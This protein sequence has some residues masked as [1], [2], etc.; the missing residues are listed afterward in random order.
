M[1]LLFS[2]A[3]RLEFFTKTVESLVKHCPD[4]N[5]LTDKVYILDDRS[6]WV[7]RASM[8]G[9][10][11]N[12]FD[13]EKITTITFNNSIEFGW[14]DKLNF[15]SKLADDTEYFFLIEDDW[16]FVSPLDLPKHLQ[17]MNFNDDIDLITFNGHWDLQVH[18]NGKMPADTLVTECWDYCGNHDY[19]ETYWANPYPNGYRHCIAERNGVRTWV[20]VRVNNFSM[21]PGIFRSNMFKNNRFEKS[22]LWETSFLQGNQYKQL[23][24]KEANVLHRGEDATLFDREKYDGQTIPGPKTVIID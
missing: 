24:L 7:D 22:D 4:I 3:R 10:L 14:V 5:S 6:T 2:T 1:I 15:I 13:S 21:N 23:F 18:E 19:N 11:T 9:L 17:F 8:E 12:I 16:E 20:G